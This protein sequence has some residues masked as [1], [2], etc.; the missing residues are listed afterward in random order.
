MSFNL[1][2]QITF[3]V[4]LS[5]DGVPTDTTDVT[6]TVTDPAGSPTLYPVAQLD[7]PGVGHYLLT[8]AASMSGMW[9]WAWSDPQLAGADSGFFIVDVTGR[10]PW[11]SLDDVL[12]C[13]HCA[14]ATDLALLSQA[15]DAASD[16]LYRRTRRMY[17]GLLRRQLRPFA[18][19]SAWWGGT[20]AFGGIGWPSWGGTLNEFIG[21]GY[22]GIEGIM[23]D[24]SAWASGRYLP[25][26]ILPDRTVDVEAVLLDG[27][28][29]VRGT[30][31]RLD[32]PNRLVRLGGRFWPYSQ[33]NRLAETE[34][35]TFSVHVIMGREPPTL[36]RWAC[37]DLACELYRDRKGQT[38]GT[39]PKEFTNFARQG[40]TI[41]LPNPADLTKSGI[42]GLWVVDRFLQMADKETRRARVTSPDVPDGYGRIIG[43]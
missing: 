28:T 30:D 22:Q 20:G 23:D 35:G 5:L 3:E 41:V 12:K 42:T 2:D 11:C 26:V 37:A 1:G 7:H 9:F 32:P 27:H 31:W 13:K 19:A 10:G 15:V 24:S 25:E 33:D 14:S 17:P 16:W 39:L 4:R 29:L 43:A 34:T 6:L 18:Q 40:V 36:G 8:L 38:T 21:G